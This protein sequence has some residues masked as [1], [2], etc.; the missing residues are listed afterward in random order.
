MLTNYVAEHELMAKLD[1]K[2]RVLAKWT[3]HG[4]TCSGETST[5]VM[6]TI[7]TV[8][9]ML[10]IC[11]SAGVNVLHFPPLCRGGPWVGIKAKGDD[12]V[13]YGDESVIEQLK[14]H[15]SVVY[16]LLTPIVD[17]H[18]NNVEQVGG[19][20]LGQIAKTVVNE[21]DFVSTIAEVADN[22]I[23]T[24]TRSL[25]RAAQFSTTVTKTL[26]SSERAKY[27]EEEI[28]GIRFMIEGRLIQGT[29]DSEQFKSLGAYL[30]STGRAL[31]DQEY[32]QKITNPI[33]R[34][35]H[36]L[37]MV[38][39]FFTTEDFYRELIKGDA[40]QPA[41]YTHSFLLSKWSG[42]DDFF[43]ALHEHQRELDF[44]TEHAV[45]LD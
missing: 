32:A 25:E 8:F 20:N 18:G 16:E 37:K 26:C 29:T 43:L 40:Y 9:Y 17:S 35:A 36:I 10:T 15:L 31:L 38:D 11:A 41:G 13:F 30:T 5:T 21:W 39:K 4:T 7:H 28:I 6:N 19:P 34:N 27:T 12:Q 42:M 2:E 14:P 23:V 33:V 1:S 24:L 44:Y 3:T 22:R 45:E